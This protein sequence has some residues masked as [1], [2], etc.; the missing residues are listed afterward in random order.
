MAAK[1][2]SVRW[3]NGR[4][5]LIKETRVM[6]RAKWAGTLSAAFLGAGLAL[7]QPPATSTP[8]NAAQDEPI[9]TLREPGKKEAQCRVLKTWH[10]AN[11]KLAYEVQSLETGEKI[12]V[13]ESTPTAIQSDAMP[14]GGLRRITSR[15]FNRSS[16]GDGTVVMEEVAKPQAQPQ[17]QPAPKAPKAIR[18]PYALFPSLNIKDA[19]S[20]TPTD[21]SA[22]QSAAIANSPQ[23]SA[24]SRAV[25]VSAPVIQD[26]GAGPAVSETVNKIVPREANQAAPAPMSPG[27]I[28]SP[29]P[30][31]IAAPPAPMPVPGSGISEMR[32]AVYGSAATTSAPAAPAALP[33]ADTAH[34]DPLKDPEHFS[35]WSQHGALSTRMVLAEAAS[36][37]PA[38]VQP[39]AAPQSRGLFSRIKQAFK[40]DKVGGTEEAEVIT[41][42]QE[43]ITTGQNGEVTVSSQ[44]TTAGDKHGE[45]VPATMMTQPT[46]YQTAQPQGGTPVNSTEEQSGQAAPAETSKD[47]PNAFARPFIMPRKRIKAKQEQENAFGPIQTMPDGPGV[48]EVYPTPPYAMLAQQMAEQAQGPGTPAPIATVTLVPGQQTPAPTATPGSPAVFVASYPG[49]GTMQSMPVSILPASAASPNSQVSFEQVTATLHHGAYPSQREWAAETLAS[50]NWRAN[51]S[52]VAELI[53]AAKDDPA[54]TVR[55][56]CVRCLGHMDPQMP[57][58]QATLQGSLSDHDERVRLEARMAVDGLTAGRSN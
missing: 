57:G 5:G 32:P 33:Q 15:L 24:E 22:R 34:P 25:P 14:G 39:A 13:L 17:A 49:N 20:A 21:S 43:V 2:E 46:A 7:A 19:T 29:A 53:K 51:P 50:A 8:T 9:V 30:A 31:P 10:D 55:A 54:A 48:Q 44:S 56:T 52:I 4:F 26:A 16:D 18:P 58:V 11:G 23:G 42:G 27:S 45:A 28:G 37:T 36:A 6:I 41:T 35:R 3:E 38:E 47:V 12:T 1:Q 40:R